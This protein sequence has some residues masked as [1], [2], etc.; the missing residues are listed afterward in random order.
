MEPETPGKIARHRV[1]KFVTGCVSSGWWALAGRATRPSLNGGVTVGKAGRGQ[2]SPAR[3]QPNYERTARP[4]SG[5]QILMW[6]VSGMM[7]RQRMKH[8]A[9]TTIG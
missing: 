7:N 2:D 1:G 5:S 4:F 8:T 6:R 9:G 3:R